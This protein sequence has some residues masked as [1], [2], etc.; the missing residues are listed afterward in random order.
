MGVPIY[1]LLPY[2]VSCTTSDNYFRLSVRHYSKLLH[3]QHP[4]LTISIFY[5]CLL[6]AL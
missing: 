6:H 3:G 2:Y 5:S 1:Y 4:S